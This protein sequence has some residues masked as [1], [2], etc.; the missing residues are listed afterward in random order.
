[1]TTKKEKERKIKKREMLI[2]LVIILLISLC[3]FSASYFFNESVLQSE[4]VLFH[5]V[6]SAIPY[7]AVSV[8]FWVMQPIATWKKPFVI[9]ATTI[10]GFVIGILFVL[11]TFYLPG[12]R[13]KAYV[14]GICSSVVLKHYGV[15]NI[16]DLPTTHSAFDLGQT[17]YRWYAQQAEC[18]ENFYTGKGPVF[19]ENPPGFAP[20]HP[21]ANWKTYTNTNYK[22]SF[23]FPE[24]D[25]YINQESENKDHVIIAYCPFTKGPENCMD[26]G[27]FTVSFYPELN[28]KR[29][30]YIQPPKCILKDPQ[31]KISEQTFLNKDWTVYDFVL[32]VKSKSTYCANEENLSA[33][34]I[35]N[36]ALKLDTGVLVVHTST[37]SDNK[38]TFEQ[39][40][41]T[42]KFIE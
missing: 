1:M 25:Y 20:V 18:V 3:F 21:T 33:G 26:L 8:I 11:S 12:S 10:L 28:V 17:F 30:V 42:F 39:M 19:S 27:Y 5:L 14:E 37:V 7:L 4:F 15:K 36:Y 32:D 22:Y 2:F 29:D 13:N 9:T 16:T 35:K 41:S 38:K 24:E 40:F 34:Y 31:T 6:I 23:K